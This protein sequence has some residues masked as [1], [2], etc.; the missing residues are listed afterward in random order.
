VTKASDDVP[1]VELKPD[2]FAA[3]EDFYASGVDVLTDASAL[4]SSSSVN[5]DDSEVVQIIKELLDTRIRPSVQVRCIPHKIAGLT[6]PSVE[7]ELS[8]DMD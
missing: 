5:E 2:I 1:W 6:S 8:W 3:I 4:M 7:P